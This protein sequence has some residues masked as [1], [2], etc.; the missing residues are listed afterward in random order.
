[1]PLFG[2]IRDGWGSKNTLKILPE[3]EIGV[4]VHTHPPTTESRIGLPFRQYFTADGTPSGS[5]DMRVDG[6]ST[7]Q[8]FCI[9]SE[10]T[11]DRYIK[12]I[13]VKLA[14]ATAQFNEFGALSA[15]TKG[16]SFRWDSQ[17][18]G[19]LTIHDGIKDNIEWFRLS[20][21]PITSNS[22]IDLSGGGADAIVIQIDLSTLF[23]SPWG[24]K[25]SAGTTEKLVF[26]VQD[27]LDS[28]IDEFNIIGYGTKF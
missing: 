18:I 2:F 7:A 13:S 21:T 8:E 22:I 4:V 19:E 27:K 11:K 5:N 24:V 26:K 23:G 16:V 20:N 10:E 28:G 12:F 14:D 17:E 15:L 6:S 9:P 3:G 1:M 25:L